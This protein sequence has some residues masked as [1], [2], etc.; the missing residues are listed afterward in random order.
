[1][2]PFDVK[3]LPRVGT[4]SW[5]I[6]TKVLVPGPASLSFHFSYGRVERDVELNGQTGTHG[7]PFMSPVTL[8]KSCNPS[9]YSSIP[10]NP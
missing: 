3:L 6:E 7:L 2:Y 1:M 8:G 4:C 10:Q 9:V 5:Y